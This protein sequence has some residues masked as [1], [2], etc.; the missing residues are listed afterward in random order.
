[1]STKWWMAYS[2]SSDR[3]TSMRRRSRRGAGV[4]AVLALSVAISGCGLLP[5]EPVEEDLSAIELPKISEKPKYD[6]E[7]KTLETTA[8]GS[9]KMMS[10]QEKTLFFTLDGKKLKKLYIRSGDTVKAGQAIGELDVDDMKKNLRTQT[11]AFKKT[12]LEMKTLLRTKD[13]MDPIDFEQR[14]LDFETSRQSLTDLQTDIDKAVLTAP[15]AGTVVSVSVQEGASIKAYDPICIVA[16]PSRLIVAASLSKDDLEK[17][18]LGMEV[19]VDINNAGQVK[20]KVKQLPQPATDNGNG[21]NGGNGQGGNGVESLDKYLLVEVANLP[22][23]VTRGTPL[24]VS[25]IVNRKENAVVIPLAALRTIGART[26][27]QVVEADGSKREVDVEVG[28]QTSTDAE[29]LNG[30]TPGQKVV[31][32]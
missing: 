31:G 6:V 23:T 10:T 21:G 15:F 28:Q 26:Y 11:L 7:T 18:A 19:Q 8:Q 20:G 17:V 13:D 12:E 3:T 25:V 4:L 24:S 9:G 27:V 2:S 14:M 29:I 5:K 1:M 30:L 22:K 16:D 32:R